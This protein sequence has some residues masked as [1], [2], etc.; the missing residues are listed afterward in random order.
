MVAHHLGTRRSIV[1]AGLLMTAA[2]VA[3]GSCRE[4]HAQLTWA[5]D[6]AGNYS[7]G[8]G[9]GTDGGLGFGPWAFSV[10]SGA[11]GFAGAFIGDPVS[12]GITNFGTQAFGLYANPAGS[13][14]SVTVLRPFD[15]PM[16]VGDTF[17]FQWAVNWD[18]NSSSGNK[19]FNLFTG[20][21]TQVLNVNQGSFPGPIVVNSATTSLAYG[22]NPMTWTMSLVSPTSLVVQATPR[23]GGTSVAYSGT[24]AVTQG[25]DAIS[26]YAS[27]MAGG[28]QRQ[29]YFNTFVG[30]NSGT[31]A[32]GG[33]RAESRGLFG[34][35]GLTVGGSTT[36]I[37]TA[38]TNAF[39]GGST[40]Q[41]GSTLQVGDGV[42]S[43]S[44]LG[45]V[46]NAGRLVFVPAGTSTFAGA[47]SGTGGVIK[48]GAGTT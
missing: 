42:S 47:I 8:W 28:D 32:T 25:P 4:A 12:A 21:T 18:S 2:L 39:T 27:Q 31:Y 23:T 6:N 37:L 17:S 3:L 7:G 24:F 26:L 16:G 11:G 40:V 41:R 45:S 43:G 1:S 36:L 44:L 9:N 38:T 10:N 14:A 33:V 20:G 30:S 35:G 48:E 5:A 34:G 15:G 46:A 13:G 19:G 29:P 22:T